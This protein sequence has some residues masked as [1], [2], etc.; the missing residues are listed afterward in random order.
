MGRTPSNPQLSLLRDQELA[1]ICTV[2]LGVSISAHSCSQPWKHD[3]M[4][5]TA[6]TGPCCLPPACC[7]PVLLS[8]P[9]PDIDECAQGLHNCS[10]LCTNTPGT[11]TCHCR[12]GFRPLDPTATLCLGEYLQQ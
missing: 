12:Q 8:S 6:T 10:Q 2:A 1:A 7:N 9:P 3:Q 4:C 5:S 11:H